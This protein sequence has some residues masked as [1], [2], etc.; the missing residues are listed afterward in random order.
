MSFIAAMLPAGAR[1]VPP[2]P[3]AALEAA[4]AGCADDAAF[5]RLQLWEC[6]PALAARANPEAGLRAGRDAIAAWILMIEAADA[7]AARAHIDA[8]AG[9]LGALAPGLMRAP[10]YRLMWALQAADA[11]APCADPPPLAGSG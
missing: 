4:C 2:A 1:K 10:V 3:R 6:D 9:R 7:A 11:P 5:V 8:V